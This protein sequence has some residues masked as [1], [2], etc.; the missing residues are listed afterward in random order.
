MEN[1]DGLYL[2]GTW[3]VKEKEDEL[4]LRF[5]ICFVKSEFDMKRNMDEEINMVTQVEEWALTLLVS[6]RRQLHYF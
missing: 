5:F 3:E 6:M 4:S 2:E 1:N